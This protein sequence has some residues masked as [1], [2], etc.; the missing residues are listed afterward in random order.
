M[1]PSDFTGSKAEV[2][3]ITFMDLDCQNSTFGALCTSWVYNLCSNKNIGYIYNKQN[4]ENRW[5]SILV[6]S[7][8]DY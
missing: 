3:W 2:F 8:S 5:V 1:E 4:L 6:C 7:V